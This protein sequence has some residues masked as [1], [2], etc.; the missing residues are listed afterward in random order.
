L[1]KWTDKH[2][3]QRS[4]EY[5]PAWDLAGAVEDLQLL[6]EVGLVAADAPTMQSWKPGDEF[7]LAR[8]QAIDQ[9]GKENP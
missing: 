2:Y 3:H 7:E 5:D 6:T 1:Q 9:A 4:D 8:K